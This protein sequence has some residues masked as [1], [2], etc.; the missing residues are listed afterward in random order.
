[1]I[2][3][4][5]KEDPVVKVEDEKKEIIETLEATTPGT[6]GVVLNGKLKSE[7][8]YLERGFILAKTDFLPGDTTAKVHFYKSA[9]A[10][11]A[12]FSSSI[13]LGLDSGATYY[14][15]AYVKR[16]DSVYAGLSKTFVYRGDAPLVI[17]EMSS[18]PYYLGDTITIKGKNFSDRHLEGYLSNYV[19]GGGLSVWRLDVKVVNDS[20]LTWMIP[21]G[22]RDKNFSVEITDVTT[23]RSKTFKSL[24][25][26]TPVIES[27]TP[28]GR[29]GDVI[30]IRGNHFDT[31][32]D[33]IK[34]AFGVGPDQ[35]PV[36]IIS[37]N[38]K[39]IKVK[40]TR[41]VGTVSRISVTTQVQTVTSTSD[42]YL[43]TANVYVAGSIISPYSKEQVAYWKNGTLVTLT[44]GSKQASATAITV[45]GNDVYTA[46]YILHGMY[47][48]SIA[49]WKNNVQVDLATHVASAYVRSIMVH[50]GDVYVT[51]HVDS[52]V[53]YWKNG[54]KI[55]LSLLPGMTSGASSGIAM[56]GNDLYISGYQGG[57]G[58]YAV[59][60]KN[61]VPTKLPN[62]FSCSAGNNMVFHKG[63]LYI[64]AVY[65]SSHK[66]AVNYWK[67]GVPMKI[68]DPS[69]SIIAMGIAVTDDD[70]YVVANTSRGMGY[71][72]SNKFVPDTELQ[73]IV[74]GIATIDNDVY[75]SGFARRNTESFAVFW[76]NGI[77]IFLPLPVGGLA[78]NGQAIAVTSF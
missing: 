43:Y 57:N 46:G 28:S 50:N 77:P 23:H 42:F 45:V 44:S 51:G 30:E 37:A 10:S 67:N 6:T 33:R 76:K 1:M 49:Y 11:G 68:S 18:G 62:T 61:G 40:L 58:Q 69:N 27:F 70:I 21:G 31:N 56:Q 55:K 38:R 52:E 78:G 36:D 59:Y 29:I 72:K 9:T 39:L 73:S 66:D 2:F 47:D 3:A 15:R 65:S 13:S 54:I 19:Q 53:V 14:Y 25:L 34:I 17:G 5:K 4:C 75:V 12:E 32:I 20:T 48:V 63:D 64:P 60:W 41:D 16:Q 24:Q 26:A 35:V 71:Y 7:E 22:L 74:S 8:A